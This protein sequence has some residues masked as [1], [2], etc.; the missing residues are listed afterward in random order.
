MAGIYRSALE[1]ERLCADL[2]LEELMK[3]LPADF[4][5]KGNIFVFVDECHRTQGGLLHEAMKH[6]MGNNVMLIGFTGTPLLR[7][8]KKKSIETFGEIIH[9]YKF[10][11]AVEDGVILD[12]RYE[13]RSVGQYLGNKETSG[14][15]QKQKV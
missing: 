5:A 2:Y 6:I 11:E 8:D 14:S 10:D 15:S 4:S 7:S 9:S 13:A 1:A 3:S 12:L